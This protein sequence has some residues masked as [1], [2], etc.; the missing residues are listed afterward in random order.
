MADISGGLSQ[1]RQECFL[2][3]AAVTPSGA[4]NKIILRRLDGEVPEGIGINP[5]TG[6]ITVAATGG[7]NKKITVI[8]KVK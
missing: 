5:A 4:N 2:Y 3:K 8:V 6:K 7:S 1:N